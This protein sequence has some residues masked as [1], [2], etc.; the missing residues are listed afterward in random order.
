[1][2][3]TKIHPLFDL[4][5]IFMQNEPLAVA[6]LQSQ[7]VK[8][9]PANRLNLMEEVLAVAELNQSLLG[10]V[11]ASS[12]LGSDHGQG[13]GF[14]EKYVREP[15]AMQSLPNS[16]RYRPFEEDFY[17]LDYSDNGAAPADVRAKIRAARSFCI[18][19][20]ANSCR[21]NIIIRE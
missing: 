2:I 17:L 6:L 19:F 1:M 4:V 3:S 16:E 7:P 5:K 18:F 11:F 20:I 13:W 15:F 21:I 8:P 14:F 9:P 12:F 10:A